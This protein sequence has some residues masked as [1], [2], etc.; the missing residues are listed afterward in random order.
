MRFVDEEYQIRDTQTGL[1]WQ[2][3]YKSNISFDEALEYATELSN[4]TC[5]EWRVPTIQELSGLIDRTRCFPA[6]Y[7]PCV[8]SNVFWSS[9]PY[10]G[11]TNFA[12]FVNFGMGDVSN[13]GRR[14]GYSV[15][16]IRYE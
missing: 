5:L 9:S 2:S 11:D 10:V 1:I 6:S 14:R 8:S 7:F 3:S 13:D 15:R 4:E 16:L 12:W